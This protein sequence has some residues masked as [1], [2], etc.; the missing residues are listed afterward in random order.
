M[1]CSR[2]NFTFFLSYSVIFQKIPQIPVLLR[3]TTTSSFLIQSR[4]L[5]LP[6]A[7]HGIRSHWTFQSCR[8]SKIYV[9]SCLS[10]V[11]TNSRCSSYPYTFYYVHF[12][13]PFRIL[14]GYCSNFPNFCFWVLCVCKR[15]LTAKKL[16]ARY[17]YALI[18]QYLSQLNIKNEEF[19][20]RVVFFGNGLFLITKRTHN[21]DY[22]NS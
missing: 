17:F 11:T 22:T 14:H 20:V 6:V 12:A 21:L 1:A 16:S 18:S 10:Q 7:K 8:E 2:A 13:L 19:V 15:T 3:R 5:L 9:L 4:H